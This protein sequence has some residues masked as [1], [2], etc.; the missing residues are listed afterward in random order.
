M[1][2]VVFVHRCV[3][4]VENPGYRA[5]LTQSAASSPRPPLS[6]SIAPAARE[7][8]LRARA[9]SAAPQAEGDISMACEAR[10]N[11]RAGVVVAAWDTA[12]IVGG[13]GEQ[14]LEGSLSLRRA[15]Q[16]WA[17]LSVTV[18]KS[19]LGSDFST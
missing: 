16:E 4:E 8:I 14:V 19:R 9:A 10:G 17:S 15:R 13:D 5:W 7:E 3:L 2:V 6:H 1:R 18:P 12:E 11:A